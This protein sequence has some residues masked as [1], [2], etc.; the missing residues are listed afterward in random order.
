MSE[1][2][3]TTYET[4]ATEYYDAIRHPTCANFR[5]ASGQVLSQWLDELP[6]G[7]GWLCE[8]GP[9]KSMLAELVNGRTYAM[10]RLV[11][12]DSSLSMLA[13]SKKWAALGANLILGDATMLPVPSGS[14]ELLVSSLGD[15]YNDIRFWKEA[16][17]VLRHNGFC[18][19][20]TPSYDWASTFRGNADRETITWAQFELSDGR[21]VRVPSYICPVDE[22][23]KAVVENGL[24]VVRVVHIP[25]TALKLTHL[26]PK[27]L[28]GRGLTATV[29]TGYLITKT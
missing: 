6:L 2:L 11:L 19:F 14:L 7:K 29:V 20:T 5:E 27:L 21:R 26:S 4:L 13:H 28:L 22:Q 9:G 18:L 3:S 15:P 8:V 25:A 12:V 10:G 16:S 24:S 17:R 1:F 23:I